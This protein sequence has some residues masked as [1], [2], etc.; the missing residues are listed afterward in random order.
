MHPRFSSDTL[1]DVCWTAALQYVA[2]EHRACVAVDDVPNLREWLHA[3]IDDSDS[4]SEVGSV[5]TV[6]LK[7]DQ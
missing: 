3:R 6:D 1:A 7:K 4:E 5:A 2:V